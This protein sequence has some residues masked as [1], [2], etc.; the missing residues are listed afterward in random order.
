MNDGNR[1]QEKIA[2]FPGSFD[3]F[4]IGHYSIVKRALAFVDHIVV[5]IGVN[6][7]KRNFFTLEARME[8]IRQAFASEPRVSV[9]SYDALTVDYAEQI[10]ANI[11]LRGIRSIKDFEYE[12]TIADA[13]RELSS[14][15]TLLLFTE[16]Q[17]SF[18]SS[19]VVRDVL[20]YGKDV[21]KMMP[22]GIDIS[23]MERA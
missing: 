21:S 10:N 19:T 12:K 3:P 5:A 2:L 14:I 16:P 22:P 4:T 9:A 8:I 6:D 1:P 20:R 15:D 17:H 13:N 11:I 23:K 18:I 7:A